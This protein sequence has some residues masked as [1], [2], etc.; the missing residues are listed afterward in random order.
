MTFT[1]INNN[2]LSGILINGKT[3]QEFYKD[4][5]INYPQF[6]SVNELDQ[7]AYVGGFPI[8]Y[9]PYFDPDGYLL[10]KGWKT[11]DKIPMTGYCLFKL[12]R[13]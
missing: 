13:F 5:P 4:I 1:Y 3:P 9:N 11:I 6:I 8:N 10:N 2:I 12:E 7:T